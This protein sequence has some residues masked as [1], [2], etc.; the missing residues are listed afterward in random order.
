MTLQLGLA[1][2]LLTNTSSNNNSRSL[3]GVT[4]SSIVLK[5][6]MFAHSTT[7]MPQFLI[8]SRAFCYILTKFQNYNL[9]ESLIK[10]FEAPKSEKATTTK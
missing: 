4:I 9:C 10:S 5:F 3:R 8:S 6:G 7:S 1:N 2:N